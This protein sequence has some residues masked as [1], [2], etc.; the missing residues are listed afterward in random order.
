MYRRVPS[1]AQRLPTRL[2]HTSSGRYFPRPRLDGQPPVMKPRPTTLTAK[3]GVPRVPSELP[4]YPATGNP[5]WKAYFNVKGWRDRWFVA[6]QQTAR[7]IVKAMNL[8]DGGP[9]KIVIEAY[10]GTFPPLFLL[11]HHLTK[12]STAR[13]WTGY[14]RVS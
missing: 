13:C 9:P 14:V 11:L 5:D 12:V 2:L 8:D 10:P 3:E 1:R 7:D 4:V 6:N